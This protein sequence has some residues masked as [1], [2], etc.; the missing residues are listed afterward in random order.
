MISL[1][2]RR[3]MKLIIFFVTNSNVPLHKLVFIT[4]DGTKSMTDQVN[5][6][7]PSVDSM[8][9]S[10]I[11]FLTTALFTS[12]FWQARDSIQRLS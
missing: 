1:I 12:K 8:M 7:L 11:S 4:T 6:L 10:L 2:G 9:T 3:V 5:V